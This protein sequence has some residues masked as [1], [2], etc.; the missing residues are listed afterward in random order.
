MYEYVWR[1]LLRLHEGLNERILLD[2]CKIEWKKTWNASQGTSAD[3]LRSA[4]GPLE[5]DLVQ[6]NCWIVRRSAWIVM[7]V[8]AV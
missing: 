1:R 7:S 8:G 2:V 5:I 3:R 4:G 6:T